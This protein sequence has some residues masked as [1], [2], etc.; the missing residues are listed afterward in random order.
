MLLT[1]YHG[2]STNP[3]SSSYLLIPLLPCHS[4]ASQDAWLYPQDY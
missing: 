1:Y 3:N 2:P 4:K